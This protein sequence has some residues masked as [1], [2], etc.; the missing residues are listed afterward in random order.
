[1]IAPIVINASATLKMNNEFPAIWNN[2]KSVTKP[3]IALSRKLPNAPA[4]IKINDTLEN[5][6]D[7]LKK[8]V[9]KKII[10]K[11]PIANNM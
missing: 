3:S 6:S 1:M 10:T 11:S 2:K 4:I 5:L 7:S 9:I 8:I